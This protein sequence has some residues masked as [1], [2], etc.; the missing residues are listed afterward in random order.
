MK[1]T[2]KKRLFKSEQNFSNL[3]D[4]IKLFQEERVNF[5]PEKNIYRNNS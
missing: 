4:G 3:G 5:G 1:N 2:E